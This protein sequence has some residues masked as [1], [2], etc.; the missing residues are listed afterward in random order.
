MEGVKMTEKKRKVKWSFLVET[1]AENMQVLDRE[2]LSDA[3]E[4]WEIPHSSV[5]GILKVE[6]DEAGIE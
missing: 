5:I 2:M 1:D 6:N 3:G 4:T